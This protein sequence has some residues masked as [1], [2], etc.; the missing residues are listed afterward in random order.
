MRA[1]F[2]TLAFVVVTL[3]L[4][5]VA[6]VGVLFDR[7]G[8]I[9]LRL[10]RVWSR[11]ILVSAGVK[12]RIRT[13]RPPDV[14]AAVR[15][16]GQSCEHVRHLVALHRDSV[17]GAHDRQEA[18]RP[19]PLL[20]L[21]HAR[22]PLHLHRS[23]ESNR[24]PPQH[25]RGGAPDKA[26]SFGADLPRRDA[27]AR[28]RVGAVQEGGLSPGDRL[29]RRHRSVRDSW[30]PPGD[31]AREHVDPPGIDR[32]RCRRTD[33]DRRSDRRRSRRPAR[34]GARADPGDDDDR[35]DRNAETLRRVPN[36]PG[37]WRCD[38]GARLRHRRVSTSRAAASSPAAAR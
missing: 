19:D 29:G 2:N 3:V 35:R 8:D 1:V 10:A 18:A 36:L 12:I 37:R 24:R 21:G 13:Q 25:R 27:H 5:I 32:G 34:Q 4:A 30:Q 28:R 22:R 20:R 9:V 33:L 16:H 26:R 31:A 23:P 14:R 11:A 6:M 17:P 38:G 15:L 7:S